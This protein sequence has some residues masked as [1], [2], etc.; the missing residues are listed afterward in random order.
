[1]ILPHDEILV[2]STGIYEYDTMGGIFYVY[3]DKNTQCFSQLM[4]FGR[5]GTREGGAWRKPLTHVS[6]TPANGRTHEANATPI[7]NKSSR[8]TRETSGL[9]AKKTKARRPIS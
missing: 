2:K 1:M 4:A 5:H 8:V 7:L 9:F 6:A 3:L